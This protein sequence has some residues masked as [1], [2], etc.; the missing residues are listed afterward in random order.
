M[1]TTQDSEP[2]LYDLFSV[3]L[4]G[5]SA[6]GGDRNRAHH[7][8]FFSSVWHT[9]KHAWLGALAGHYHAYIR[10]VAVE[11]EWKRPYGKTTTEKQQE[12]LEESDEEGDEDGEAREAALRHIELQLEREAKLKAPDMETVRVAVV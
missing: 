7:S 1:T 10:D 11:G 4:H 8:P 9:H 6:H 2:V 3:I 12:I 5:G